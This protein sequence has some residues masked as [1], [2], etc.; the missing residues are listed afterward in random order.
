MPQPASTPD[1]P[2]ETFLAYWSRLSKEGEGMIQITGYRENNRAM[3]TVR[4]DGHTAELPVR[5][6]L[7]NHSPDGF[8]WGYLGSGPA[9]LSL[10]ILAYI[11][12]DDDVALRFYQQFKQDIVSRFDKSWTLTDKQ[13]TEWLEERG[14]L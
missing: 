5:L 6:D 1:E 14:E 4:N 7:V 2:V 10:A 12:K 9:Q 3:V 8:E 11:T 13:V